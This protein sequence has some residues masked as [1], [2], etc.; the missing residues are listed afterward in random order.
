MQQYSEGI[1]E[2]IHVTQMFDSVRS[3]NVL[4][5]H[6]FNDMWIG[7]SNQDMHVYMATINIPFITL[8]E[9]WVMYST[10]IFISHTEVGECLYQLVSLT[11]LVWREEKHY[12]DLLSAMAAF[13]AHQIICVRASCELNRDRSWPTVVSN[14]PVINYLKWT[15]NW[16]SIIVYH[17]RALHGS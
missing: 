14:S 2:T 4:F 8:N 17:N 13:I 5:S 6:I 12:T 11:L 16:C 9:K 3:L 1:C 15:V 10:C 7:H